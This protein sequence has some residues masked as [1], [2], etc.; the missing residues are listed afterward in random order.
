MMKPEFQPFRNTIFV[1]PLLYLEYLLCLLASPY[2]S[3]PPPIHPPVLTDTHVPTHPLIQGASIYFLQL[4]SGLWSLPCC[5]EGYYLLLSQ[6]TDTSFFYIICN[7]KLWIFICIFFS[8]IGTEKTHTLPIPEA[9]A[10][11]T[12]SNV[13]LWNQVDQLEDGEGQVVL[14]LWKGRKKVQEE[15]R[16]RAIG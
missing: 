16:H 11:S 13:C 10:V 15:K 9:L 7:V 14:M 8:F 2:P 4:G 12:V 1:Y 3:S 6:R 5:S